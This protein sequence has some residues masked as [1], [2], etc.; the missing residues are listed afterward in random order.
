M[1]A[2]PLRSVC[3]ALLLLSILWLSFDAPPARADTSLIGYR[4]CLD[5]G[6]GGDDPG[7]ENGALRESDV[8]LDVML[9]LRSLLQNQGATVVMT[10]DSD[11]SV[12]AN[13]RLGNCAAGVPDFLIALHLHGGTESASDG[14]TS[15]Y[16][17]AAD[18]AL[19]LKLHQALGSPALGPVAPSVP[20]IDFGLAKSTAVILRKSSLAAA[21]VEPVLL[22]NPAEA[23][24]LSQRVYDP[25][26]TGGLD[27]ACNVLGAPCR[28]LQIVRAIY[29]GIFLYL[30]IAP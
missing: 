23:S 12:S 2:R 11:S 27:P 1:S 5:P 8:A 3:A 19:A 17:N 21:Q 26:A 25:S 15:R 16:L 10:R 6:H 24:A 22:T 14:F 13:E 20:L 29:L 30:G 9:A 28:R 18:K 7:T 4:I